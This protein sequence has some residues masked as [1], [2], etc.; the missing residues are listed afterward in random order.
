MHGH[1]QGVGF[2]WA[3]RARLAEL[4]LDGAATNRDDGTVEVVA[5]GDQDALDELARWLRGGGTPG[6]VTGVDVPGD[7]DR[8]RGPGAPP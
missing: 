7:A 6:R 2:R 1:V 5:S 3:T 8:R 4:G